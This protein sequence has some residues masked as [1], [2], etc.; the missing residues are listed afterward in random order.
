M[1]FVYPRAAEI[2]VAK[3]A[4]INNEW[5][6][7]STGRTV[8]VDLAFSGEFYALV[9]GEAAGVP[10]DDAHVPELRRLGQAVCAAVN[11]AVSVAHPDDR[12]VE[13]VTGVLF[14][15]PA[16]DDAAHLRSV[17]V[18]A[19]GAVDC[20][21]DRNVG[22]LGFARDLAFAHDSSGFRWKFARLLAGV[23]AFCH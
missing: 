9:D 4:F 15:G 22:F 17:L 1:N 21:L 5:V 12:T 13:G 16:R 2:L 11:H 6:P 18:T 10:L 20:D 3:G 19:A 14:T 8:P 7:V 23:P